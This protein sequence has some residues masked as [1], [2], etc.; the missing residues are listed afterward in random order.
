MQLKL[1]IG[2]VNLLPVCDLRC[3]DD[4]IRIHTAVCV[5][6]YVHKYTVS[7]VYTYRA[8]YTDAAGK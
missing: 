4:V 6:M 2:T 8:R 7:G 3:D 5:Y 1:S